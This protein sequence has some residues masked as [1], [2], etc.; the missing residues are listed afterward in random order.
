MCHR[1]LVMKDGRIMGALTG[2]EISEAEIMFLATGVTE[3][4][5]PAVNSR[6]RQ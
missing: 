1:V 6:I 5:K 4:P 3:K 2:D